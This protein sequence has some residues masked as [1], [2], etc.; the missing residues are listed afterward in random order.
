MLKFGFTRNF[1]AKRTHISSVLCVVLATFSDTYMSRK[2]LVHIFLTLFS[3]Q[4][5]RAQVSNPVRVNPKI[6]VNFSDLIFSTEPAQTSSLAEMGWNVGVDLNYGNKW[7]GKWGLHYFQLGSGVQMPSDTQRVTA[8]QVKIPFGAGYRVLKVDY[9]HLW[10]HG[11]AVVNVTTRLRHGNRP[12]ARSSYPRTG[13]AGR[14]GLGMDLWKITL[15]LNYEYSFTEILNE[16]IFA[17][18]KMVSLSLGIKI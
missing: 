8:S 11:Q 1:L 15:E 18:N 4:I 3:I 5:G 12:L 6:G 14:F 9:F 17:R 16:L 13:L 2:V 10:V 7:Q